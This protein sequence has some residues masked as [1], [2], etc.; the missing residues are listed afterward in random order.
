MVQGKFVCL[1][2]PQHLKNKFGNIYTMTIKFKTD[3]DDNTVQDLKDFIAEV[4][5][6]KYG[7]IN[8]ASDKSCVWPHTL[9]ALCLTVVSHEL[10]VCLT[11]DNEVF[12]EMAVSVTVSVYVKL[13]RKMANIC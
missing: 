3:T 13:S 7:W 5:P 12:G 6:G 2:S 1:G 9:H 8:S 11:S 10:M 4:F